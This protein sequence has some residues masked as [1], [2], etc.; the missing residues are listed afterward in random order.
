MFN[1]DVEITIMTKFENEDNFKIERLCETFKKPGT[2]LVVT[3]L[4]DKENV[5]VKFITSKA[6]VKKLKE[7]LNVLNFVGIEGRMEIK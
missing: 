6:C 1:K 3:G 4:A 2:I 5:E 7:Y